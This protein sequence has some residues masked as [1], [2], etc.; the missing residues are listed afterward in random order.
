MP[1]ILPVRAAATAALTLALAGC[2]GG[3]RALK[4]SA[5]ASLRPALERYAHQLHVVDV[6]LNFGGSDLLAAQIRAG[7]RFDVFAAANAKLP[8]ALFAEGRVDRPV[9]FARNRLVLGVPAGSHRVRS[10]ADLA[11]P[12]IRLAI[13]A[14]SVPVGAYTGQVLGRLPGGER[15]RILG[16]V[17][18]REPDVAG[19]VGKLA[20][21][22]VDA[23]FVY[24]TDVTAAHGRIRPIELPAALRPRV[25]Y[26]AAVVRGSKRA[27]QA[28]AFIDGLLRGAGQRTLREAGFEPPR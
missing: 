2:G 15:R 10:L 4:V 22:A 1:R 3:S 25:V 5:A 7:A 13:G 24:V 6:R 28:R 17:R 9:A 26:E 12:G 20:E 21:G 8:E 16:H 23:G 11:K 19:I 27:R 18:S 14:P